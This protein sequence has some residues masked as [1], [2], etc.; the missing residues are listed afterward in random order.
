MYSARCERG[1]VEPRLHCGSI[2]RLPRC[3]WAKAPRGL[4]LAIAVS[5]P[6]SLVAHS[7]PKTE[8]Q[9]DAFDYLHACYDLSAGFSLPLERQA[10]LVGQCAKAQRKECEATRR[11]LQDTGNRDVSLT[12]V[13]PQ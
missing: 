11:I 10:M 13:G 5:A 12:C 6:L 8:M 2:Q 9:Q 3:G 7:Q 4:V 1:H